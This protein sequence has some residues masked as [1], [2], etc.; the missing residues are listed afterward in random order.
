MNNETLRG[1]LAQLKLVDILRILRHNKRTGKLSLQFKDRSADIYFLN[2]DI[3]HAKTNDSYGEQVIYDV[4]GLRD[5]TF[6]FYP[7]ISVKNPTINRP[8]SEIMDKAEFIDEDWEEINK[9]I[10]DFGIVFKMTSGSPK[11]I[12]LNALEWN[13]LRHINGK[14]SVKDIAEKVE[15]NMLD[16][17]KVFVKLYNAGLIEVAGESIEEKPAAASGV[18]PYIFAKISQRLA[19]VVGPLAEIIVEDAIKELGEDKFSFPKEKLP[20][21]VDV[22][23]KEVSDPQKLIEFQKDMLNLIKNV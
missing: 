12:S 4:L 20:D 2:G 10:P 17:C 19:E 5:G 3:I 14:E 6:V 15:L 23:S 13:V 18:D 11:E 22:L 21:L 16:V 7:N 8:T 9:I 1:N